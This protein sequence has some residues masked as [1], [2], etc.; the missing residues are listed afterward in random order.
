M[1]SNNSSALLSSA[2][3]SSTK[4]GEKSTRLETPML[5]SNEDRRVKKSRSKRT[6]GLHGEKTDSKK[7]K[8]KKEKRDRK[9]A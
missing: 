4:A 5:S 2:Q 3:K 8:G 7:D 9:S 1:H 6:M